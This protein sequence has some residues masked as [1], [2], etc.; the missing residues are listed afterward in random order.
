[1]LLKLITNTVLIFAIFSLWV[2][3]FFSLELTN[4]GTQQQEGK[5]PLHIWCNRVC[6]P[7]TMSPFC[8]SSINPNIFHTNDIVWIWNSLNLTTGNLMKIVTFFCKDGILQTY[9]TLFFIP[10][11]IPTNTVTVEQVFVSKLICL[12]FGHQMARQV[13]LLWI[14]NYDLFNLIAAAQ[15]WKLMS[16]SFAF[17]QVSQQLLHYYGI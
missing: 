16:Y 8:C 5:I 15:V 14:N 7:V 11:G 17:F 10:V 2:G 9:I 12:S 4:K 6:L 3:H 13:V 1:M